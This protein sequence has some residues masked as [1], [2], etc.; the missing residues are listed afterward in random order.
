MIRVNPTWFRRLAV[1][2]ARTTT[3]N[4]ETKPLEPPEPLEHQNQTNETPKWYHWNS[5][6]SE[7]N[8][9]KQ[10]QKIRKLLTCLPSMVI[11][12]A[13]FLASSHL[14]QNGVVVQHWWKGKI[15]RTPYKAVKVEVEEVGGYH[16]TSGRSSTTVGYDI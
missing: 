15:N 8:P 14:F 16:W 2:V 10:H 9:R 5:L 12:W 1:R 11:K 13:A 7:Q 3:W 4:T 6:Q